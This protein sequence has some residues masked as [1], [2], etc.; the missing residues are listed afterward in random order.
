VGTS[1]GGGGTSWYNTGGTWT[2]R[3]KITINHGKV[4]GGADLM[5]FPALVSI[6]DAELK[7]AGKV[8]IPDLSASND[9]I[10]YLYYGNASAADQ[11]NATSVW[12]GNYKIVNHFKETSGNISDSSGNNNVGVP[13]GG[14]SSTSAGLIGNAYNFDGSTGMV[15][16]NNSASWATTTTDMT[17]EFWFKPNAA[18]SDYLNLM[19]MG[20]WEANTRFY[21]L[22]N[23]G[24]NG[25]ISQVANPW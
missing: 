4:S 9:T 16:I 7:S 15:A 25:D 1:G 2:N 3:R 21:E 24:L 10:V 17:L 20:N 8:Q 6:T 11:Q 12:S 13:S 23:G 5:S 19:S 14:A 18:S 22:A